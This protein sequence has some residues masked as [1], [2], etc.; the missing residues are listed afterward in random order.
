MAGN[1]PMSKVEKVLKR[2][3]ELSAMPDDAFPELARCLVELHELSPRLLRQY[4]DE[5]GVK[6]RKAYY[7]VELGRRLGSRTTA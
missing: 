5:S 2:A 6:S 4:C 1:Y 7:L 3:I